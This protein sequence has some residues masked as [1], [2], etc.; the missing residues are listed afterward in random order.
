MKKSDLKTGML[1]QYRR[2][3]IRMFINDAFVGYNMYLPKYEFSD[4][5]IHRREEFDIVNVSKVLSGRYLM[6]EN[7]TVETLN[8]NLLWSRD[9]KKYELDGVEYS[10]TTLRNLIRTA[11]QISPE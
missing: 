7:W 2:G 5:L 10:E 6:P 11:T 3:E 8:N 1:V 4:N 9:E